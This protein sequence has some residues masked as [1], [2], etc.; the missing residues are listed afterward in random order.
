SPNDLKGEIYAVV[1]YPFIKVNEALN[2]SDHW[3]DALILHVNIKYCHASTT[4]SGNVLTVDIGNKLGQSLVDAYRV[5]FNY[6]EMATTPEYFA[7]QL[8][9]QN[10]PLGTSNY[11]IWVEATPL[12][13]GRTF[14]HFTYAYSFGLSGRLAMKTYL[15]TVGRNKV[16][17]TING[18]QDDGQPAYIKGVR[19]VVERNTMRYYL[20]IDTYIAEMSSA[21]QD[22][23]ELRLQRW[24]SAT[25]LYARQLHELERI[26]YLKMKRLEYQRQQTAQ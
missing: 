10:G 26:D 5:N 24:Y 13:D 21:R 14:L 1:D 19:G 12:K 22:Q 25:E 20:A 6:R 9:A 23:L 18:K 3:C 16:G 8:S 4:K 15:A 11:R 2:N 7:V 17:F